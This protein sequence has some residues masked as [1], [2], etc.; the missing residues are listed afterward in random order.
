MPDI[1]ANFRKSGGILV[2]AGY[3][4][5]R[6]RLRGGYNSASRSDAAMANFAG[7]DM[8]NADDG[9]IR[10]RRLLIASRARN[11]FCNNS[12][13]YGII[14]T[15]ANDTI[16]TGPRLQLVAADELMDETEDSF[17]RLQRREARFHAWARRVHFNELLRSA[18]L[19]KAIDGESFIVL[20]AN[21]GLGGEV[22]LQPSIR[23]AENVASLMPQG[24]IREYYKTGE[25]VEVDG[26]RYDKNGNPLTY[27]FW[28]LPPE[29]PSGMSVGGQSS[30]I[31]AKYV[32]HYANLPRVGQH[33]GVSEMS[34]ALHVF[35]DMRRYST[36]VVLAA[37]IA[38]R[39]SFIIT[40]QLDPQL[41]SDKHMGDNNQVFFPD[42][43]SDP[44]ESPYDMTPS[45][46]FME[47]GIFDGIVLPDGYDAKQMRAEQPTSQYQTFLK[48]KIEEAA[49]VF[50]MPFNVAAGN[51]SSYNYASGR[52]DHQT[53]HKA[54]KVER[55]R[56]EDVILSRVYAAWEEFDRPL[57]W[58]DYVADDVEATW[59][60]DGFEHVDPVKEAN[61]QAVRLANGV[62]TLA[63]EC[64]R[65]GRDYLTVIRQRRR[66]LDHFRKQ[67]PDAMP[68]WLLN[69]S[70]VTSPD[71]Q[72]TRP[73]KSE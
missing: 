41:F 39:V 54:L 58:E 19:A 48:A 15:L 3:S 31:Q 66:E 4:P 67:T 36:A 20:A 52:L 28:P 37:E 40:N 18:R 14:W 30:E 8:L 23:P 61:A 11:E 62:T 42:M 10:S 72:D 73:E 49:R 2:P 56:I 21:P 5:P 22:I 53:Y 60:W 63:E 9:L 69:K 35:N 33:R 6:R 38:A 32:I 47:G 45:N 27:R 51:S 43:I 57:H 25:P 46:R 55:S 34:P 70:V 65:E 68:P 71:S 59:M 24:M 26:I 64:A 1:S 44:N 12:Y 17:K 7:S 50:Q 29:S 13:A 16:G